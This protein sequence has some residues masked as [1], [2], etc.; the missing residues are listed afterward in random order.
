[1]CFSWESHSNYRLK[2]HV[3]GR[4]IPWKDL[5]SGAA[6]NAMLSPSSDV[7]Y[8]VF[9]TLCKEHNTEQNRHYTGFYW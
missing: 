2:C 9:D 3:C 5:E 7:S 6:R 8:E 1:M 4:F